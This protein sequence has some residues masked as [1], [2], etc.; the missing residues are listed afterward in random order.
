MNTQRTEAN[1][2]PVRSLANGDLRERQAKQCIVYFIEGAGLIKIGSTLNIASRFRSIRG[3]SPV[4]VSLIGTIPGG[5]PLEGLLHAKF[6]EHH[7][8]GE[9]FRDCPTIRDYIK[10]FEQSGRLAHPVIKPGRTFAAQP[11]SHR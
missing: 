5:G 8:H 9:W 1:I 4:P 10:A 11:A 7:S 6:A 2:G 3:S